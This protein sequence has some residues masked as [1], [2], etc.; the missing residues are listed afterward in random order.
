MTILAGM[1]SQKPCTEAGTGRDRHDNCSK[2]IVGIPFDPGKQ[3]K[4]AGVSHFCVG[5]YAFHPL[6]DWL[7]HSDYAVWSCCVR[8]QPLNREGL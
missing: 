5:E 2:R 7:L 3:R 8:R 1:L 4:S 6:G